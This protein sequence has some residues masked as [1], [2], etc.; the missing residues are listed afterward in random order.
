MVDR[1]NWG[2]ALFVASI[3]A[4]IAACLLTPIADWLSVEALQDS[5][6]SLSAAIAQ[7]PWLWSAAFFL[8]CVAATAVCFPAAPVLGLAGGALF[9]IWTGLALVLTASAIG[10]TIA[11]FNARLVLRDWTARHFRRRIEAV[12]RGIAAHGGLYL[13][14]LRVNPIVPYW[15]VNVTM[16]LTAIRPRTYILLTPLGLFPAT[17]LYVTAGAQIPAA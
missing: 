2:P 6:A 15:L 16:G 11:F 17:L 4:V 3:A 10:S 8:G 13:L 1:R 14:M 7:R 12:D 5:R 9:G